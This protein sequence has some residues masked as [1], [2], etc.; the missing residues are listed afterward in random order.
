MG[1]AA[2]DREDGTVRQRWLQCAPAF[3]RYADDFVVLCTTKEQ[4]QQVKQRL[5]DWLAPKGLAF[6]EDKGGG[7][8]GPRRRRAASGG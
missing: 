3:V 4:A 2:G 5:A 7:G 1:T 8:D 6:N